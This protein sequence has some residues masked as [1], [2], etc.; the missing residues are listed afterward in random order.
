MVNLTCLS[1]VNNSSPHLSVVVAE[2]QLTE[3]SPPILELL[4]VRP[5]T[6]GCSMAGHMKQQGCLNV[7]GGN[8]AGKS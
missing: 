2:G 1:S 4:E 8:D 5:S 6:N 3:G 7:E